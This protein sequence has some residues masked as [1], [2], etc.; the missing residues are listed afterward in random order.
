MKLTYS[1]NTIACAFSSQKGRL[2]RT[3]HYARVSISNVV[4]KVQL[5]PLQEEG[6]SDGMNGSISPSLRQELQTVY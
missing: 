5:I 3:M 2:L 4:E 1:M 6:S